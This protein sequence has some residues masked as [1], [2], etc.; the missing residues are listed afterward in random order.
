MYRTIR[1]ILTFGILSSIQSLAI[2]DQY[3][4]Y[5]LVYPECLGKSAPL[6]GHFVVTNLTHYGST[7]RDIVLQSIDIRIVSPSYP[8]YE[9]VVGFAGWNYNAAQVGSTI[10]PG[11]SKTIKFKIYLRDNWAGQANVEYRTQFQAKSRGFGKFHDETGWFEDSNGRREEMIVER[12][13]VGSSCCA[14]LTA[15]QG[16]R[17][18]PGVVSIR[19]FRDQQIA[20]SKAGKNF[21]RVANRFYYSFS[22]EVAQILVEHPRLKKAANILLYPFV[23]IMNFS[24]WVFSKFRGLPE[25]AFLLSLVTSSV[26]IGAVYLGLPAAA[27]SFGRKRK[28]PF[29]NRLYASCGISLVLS[30]VML[31]VAEL[32]RSNTLMAITS[33]MICVFSVV[34]A[35]IFVSDHANRLL[36][37]LHLQIQ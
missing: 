23:N 37:F 22:P 6:E 21:L 8:Y 5:S 11:H 19:K 16:S 28:S 20:Q 14:I 17:L 13:V 32:I 24:S 12:A 7:R 35:T 15:A 29:I 2:A 25:V 3:V 26:L 1:A 18:A 30:I 31:I 36:K 10:S 34:L 9:G 4:G 33:S 27:F